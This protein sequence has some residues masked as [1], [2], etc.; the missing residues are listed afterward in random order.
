MAK[1]KKDEYYVVDSLQNGLARMT[2]FVNDEPQKESSYTVGRTSCQC[3]QAGRGQCRHMKMFE[4]W[5]S[6]PV[7]S[8][9]TYVENRDKT[10]TVSAEPLAEEGLL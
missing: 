10:Y 7:R 2:K 9:M 5:M 6:D 8:K 3:F 1:I 4:F